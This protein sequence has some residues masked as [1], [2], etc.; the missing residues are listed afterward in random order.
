M[1]EILYI[2]FEVDALAT[3]HPLNPP[4]EDVQTLEEITN[5]FDVISY[6]KVQ[7]LH[8]II[9]N[10]SQ[11]FDIIQLYVKKCCLPLQLK[12]AMTVSQVTKENKTKVLLKYNNNNNYY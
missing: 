2:A 11:K 8:I 3:S 9:V 12:S 4:E 1:T 6:R 10:E 5:M 7:H